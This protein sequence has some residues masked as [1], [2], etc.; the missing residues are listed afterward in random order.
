[1][2][3]SLGWLLVKYLIYICVGHE[4][5][6]IEGEGGTHADG[7]AGSEE[8]HDGR[9]EEAR[10]AGEVGGVKQAR[11]GDERELVVHEVRELRAERGRDAAALSGRIRG[12]S[13]ARE[14]RGRSRTMDTPAMWARGQPTCCMRRASCVV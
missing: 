14:R 2:G 6:P 12:Q 9:G 13:G 11:R 5:S 3:S 8:L 7:P 1:M 10:R 4:E